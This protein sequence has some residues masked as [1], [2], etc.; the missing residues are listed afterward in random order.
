M[1]R[2]TV[3]GTH[4]GT[5]HGLARADLLGQGS[6]GF[7][8]WLLSTVQPNGQRLGFDGAAVFRS[9]TARC[10][11]SRAAAT[12]HVEVDA[13]HLG[14]G[15]PNG[16]SSSGCPPCP[17]AN[18][19]GIARALNWQGRP[20]WQRRGCSPP[21]KVRRSQVFMRGICHLLL[22]V[23]PS[24]MGHWPVRAPVFGNRSSWVI[25]AN[26]TPAGVVQ[27][28]DSSTVG[29]ETAH[30]SRG[31]LRLVV[32]KRD[33]CPFVGGQQPYATGRGVGHVWRR[34][35]TWS[36]QR[37]GRVAPIATR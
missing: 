21:Q 9:P 4:T 27:A 6:G 2:W 26:T 19:S 22:L 8:M 20:A 33:G 15:G 11:R 36:G 34:S 14:P 12:R 32:A 16:L 35:A 5:V 10:H 18:C 30:T 7:R 37:A 23:C 24:A 17:E 3:R 29:R 31:R 28:A 1:V 13:S 25:A